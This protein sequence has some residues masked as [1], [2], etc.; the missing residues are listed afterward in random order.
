MHTN[1]TAIR[2]QILKSRGLQPIRYSIQEHRR[3]STVIGDLS[4][5]HKTPL[6]KYLEVL[7]K[8]SIV[9][10]LAAGS[11]SHIEKEYAIDRTTASKW[12]KEITRQLLMYITKDEKMT[13]SEEE[14]PVGYT[15]Y[16]GFPEV[17]AT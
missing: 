15:A 11:L 5:L 3:L 7:H 2:D 13:K 10:I 8:K 16:Q 17:A 14:Q 6:M 1:L 9:D 12:R 4:G